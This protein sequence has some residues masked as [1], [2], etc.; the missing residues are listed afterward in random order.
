MVDLFGD[1]DV[2]GM[3]ELLG[4]VAEKFLSRESDHLTKRVVDSDRHIIGIAEHHRRHVLFERQAK[5]LLGTDGDARDRTADLIPANRR[6][7]LVP[8]ALIDAHE[9]C[10]RRERLTNPARLFE[11]GIGARLAL[12]RTTW[13]RRVG[14]EVCNSIRRR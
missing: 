9:G 13:E 5:A 4:I 3:R 12:I 2:L 8:F 7:D 11:L 1:T 10:T 6:H 14:R